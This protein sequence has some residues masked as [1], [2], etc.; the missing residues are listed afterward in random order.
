MLSGHAS[1]FAEVKTAKIV[2]YVC[3]IATRELNQSQDFGSTHNLGL[4]TGP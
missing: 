3:F 1:K 4:A 2:S